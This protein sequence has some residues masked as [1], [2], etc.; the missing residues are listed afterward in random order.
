[1]TPSDLALIA[2]MREWALDPSSLCYV[3]RGAR[4]SVA[5]FKDEIEDREDADLIGFIRMR[6]SE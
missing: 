6:C 4:G 3:L 2:A 5:I 1:M